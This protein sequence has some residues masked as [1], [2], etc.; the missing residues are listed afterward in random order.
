MD[1]AMPALAGGGGS[2][3]EVDG[4]G[5]NNGSDKNFKILEL[6]ALSSISVSSPTAKNER[7]MAHGRLAL[8]SMCLLV[9]QGTALVRRGAQREPVFGCYLALICYVSMD[10]SAEN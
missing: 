4:P 6:S 5:V 7:E 1:R 2:A 8:G 3:N 9:L 10:Q